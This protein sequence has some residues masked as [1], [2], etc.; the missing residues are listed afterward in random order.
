MKQFKKIAAIMLAGVM[1]LT[2]LAGCG[3]SSGTSEEMELVNIMLKAHSIETTAT[4]KSSLIKE[5]ENYVSMMKKIKEVPTSVAD[6]PENEEYA[7]IREQNGEIEH[8]KN[9][10]RL[11]LYNRH[12]LVYEVGIDA[13]RGEGPTNDAQCAD[14]VAYKI[15]NLQDGWVDDERG[16]VTETYWPGQGYDNE[17]DLGKVKVTGIGIAKVTDMPENVYADYCSESCGHVSGGDYL[18]HTQTFTGWIVMISYE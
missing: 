10:K 14:N 8:Q 2:M 17:V 3:G 13:A 16:Y 11:E 6:E 15:K 12:I 1:A 5:A 9:V 18:A 7:E 4:E